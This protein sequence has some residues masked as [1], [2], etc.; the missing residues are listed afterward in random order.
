MLFSKDLRGRHQRGLPARF[1]GQQHRGEGDKGL[2]GS[3]VAL[4]KAIHAARC[5]KIA[6]DV[7]YN[8]NLRVRQRIRQGLQQP[9]EQTAVG[10][11][12]GA[13]K[14]SPL[15]PSCVNEELDGKKLLAN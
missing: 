12:W 9:V 8:F 4:K 14:P 10:L 13:R 1:D 2:A 6:T 15:V 3:D 5:R 7:G 11:F